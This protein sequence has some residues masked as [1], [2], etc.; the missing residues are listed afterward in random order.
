M[1]I[2]EKIV[3]I[4]TSTRI[5]YEKRM[6]CEGTSLRKNE[7]YTSSGCFIDEDGDEVVLVLELNYPYLS[8]RFRRLDYKFVNNVLKDIQKSVLEETIKININ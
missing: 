4:D 6:I 8:D 5:N 7:I 3:C 1:K 2:G